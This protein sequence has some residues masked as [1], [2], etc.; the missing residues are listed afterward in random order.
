MTNKEIDIRLKSVSKFLVK[1]SEEDHRYSLHTQFVILNSCM[2][3]LFNM[4]G[5][6]AKRLPEVKDKK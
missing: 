6:I 4:L 2:M 3:T 1:T 5:E